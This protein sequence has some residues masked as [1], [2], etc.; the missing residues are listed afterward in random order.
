MG[1][2]VGMC[3]N[4]FHILQVLASRVDQFGPEKLRK[5]KCLQFASWG[6]SGV[7]AIWNF[8]TLAL[9]IFQTLAG[10]QLPFLPKL[11]VMKRQYNII[12][13]YIYKQKNTIPHLSH[14]PNKPTTLFL[15]QNML[16][17]NLASIWSS[18]STSP[19][20]LPFMRSW[21]HACKSIVVPLLGGTATITSSACGWKPFCRKSWDV[22]KVWMWRWTGHNF[23]RISNLHG[24]VRRHWPPPKG[25][26]LLWFFLYCSWG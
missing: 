23:T 26:V 8:R 11:K 21:W 3:L 20:H 10:W 25:F 15:V 19:P 22:V 14:P 17:L 6:K 12:Y 2:I 9:S 13:I 24:I 1:F 16:F 18:K 7:A 4:F 5:K